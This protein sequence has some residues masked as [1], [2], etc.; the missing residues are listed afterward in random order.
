[1]HRSVATIDSPEFLNLQPL[2]LNPLMSKCEIKVL[3]IGA[4]RNR[5]YISKEVA[6]KIGENLR[7]API[8]GYYRDTKEDF[9][10]HGEKI[11]ID[12]EGIKFE[13][14]TFPY[15]FVSPDAQVWFQDFEDF[16]A[17]G[18][19]VKHT[20]LMT[21]GYLW[22]GIFTESSLPVE[23]GRPQS[24]EFFEASVKGKWEENYA[25]GM[26]FYIVDDAIVQK[27]CIL[28]DDVEPCFEG[29][30][31]TA[32]DASTKFTLDDNFKH[33]LYSMM[34]DLKNVLEGERQMDKEFTQVEQ[35]ETPVVEAVEETTP[36]TEFTAEDTQETSENTTETSSVTSDYAAKEDDKKKS[37]EDAPEKKDENNSDS[38]KKDDKEEE[39][40]DDKKKKNDKFAL[41]ES[42]LNT[43]KA[44]YETLQTKYQELVAFK[45]EI[46]NQKKDA[47]ISEFYMLAD[48]DKAD[49][50]QNKEKY[51]LD[52]I[53]A[54]LSVI[55]F[56]KKIN[57]S[58]EKPA[59][60]EEEVPIV[61]YALEQ[62]SDNLPDWVKAVKEE[63]K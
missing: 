28:G 6:T 34:Q 55:C 9:T 59:T 15:G 22:T 3:Y 19:S 30:S 23:E 14:Q 43:L 25:N 63:M 33:T 20:Y 41:L 27:L 5:T 54:K 10:D 44:E 16:D 17:F 39:G 46:D 18:N 50:I 60:R 38:D 42:E 49:V 32:P 4:N 40:E 57:F 8:V 21:T 12:D 13:C 1:M 24:M 56:D 11:I 61:T 45:T 31:V 36:A 48:E 47:L 29:A 53:K 7:G 62:T 52:E 51:T 26:D 2:D 37:E 35:T 58:L